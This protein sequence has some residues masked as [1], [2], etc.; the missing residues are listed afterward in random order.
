MTA[1]DQGADAVGLASG[2]A[3]LHAVFFT[4]LSSGDYV[5]VGDVTYETAFRLFS[6]L[7]PQK[8]GIDAE[9]VTD[10]AFVA[11]LCVITSAVSLGHDRRSSAALDLI[12]A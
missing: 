9:S 10:N 2:V 11:N 8:Y 5:G 3:A 1:P 4:F 7:L 6:E 12:F